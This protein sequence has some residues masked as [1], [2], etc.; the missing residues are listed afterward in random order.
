MQAKSKLIGS[1]N[2]SKTSKKNPF[3]EELRY[4]I[5]FVEP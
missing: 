4:A 2:E 1:L 3:F 5:L